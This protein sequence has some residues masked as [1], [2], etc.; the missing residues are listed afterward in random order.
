MRRRATSRA[1]A[2]A[3]L[4]VVPVLV[5]VVLVGCSDPSEQEQLVDTLRSDFDMDQEE[6]ECVADQLFERFSAEE[7]DTLREAGGSR[8]EV[9]EEL[10]DALRT[11]LT[12]C[13]GS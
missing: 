1:T 4:L 13:A 6:A 11:A 12:P 5:A 7:I 8:D 9:P 2:L 10:L 3:A